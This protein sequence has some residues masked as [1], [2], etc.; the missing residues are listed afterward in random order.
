M[1]SISAGQII[2]VGEVTLIPIVETSLKSRRFK[3]GF[4]CLGVKKPV[5]V[6]V[7][8]PQKNY[9]LSMTG[10]EVPVEHYAEQFPEIREL[11][12]VDKD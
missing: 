10:E 7:A 3:R 2:T 4:I 1:K 11:L 6:V 12:Q 9:A 8:S 5:A